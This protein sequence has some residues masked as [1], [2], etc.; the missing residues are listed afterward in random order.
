MCQGYRPRHG[1]YGGRSGWITSR[2]LRNRKMQWIWDVQKDDI[3][4]VRRPLAAVPSSYEV[5]HRWDLLFV[6]LDVGVSY[7]RQRG[8]FS[9]D[10]QIWDWVEEKYGRMSIARRNEC[11]TREASSSQQPPVNVPSKLP[12]AK[13]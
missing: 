11:F 3:I 9:S 13:L 12:S 8:Y 7:G 2:H 10:T 6:N 5:M 1:V 4:A